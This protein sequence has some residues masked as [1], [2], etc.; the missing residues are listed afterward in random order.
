MT[1][2]EFVQ[3]LEE[4]SRDE[5]RAAV[6][7]VAVLNKKGNTIKTFEVEFDRAMKTEAIATISFLVRDVEVF[8]E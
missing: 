8:D 1:V 3:L 5:L 7:E 2:R 6:F 4:A